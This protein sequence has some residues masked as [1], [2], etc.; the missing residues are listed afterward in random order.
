M[1][2]ENFN[3]SWHKECLKGGVL[4]IPDNL[5][6]LSGWE[7]HGCEDIRIMLMK[8][9]LTKILVKKIILLRIAHIMFL[10]LFLMDASIYSKISNE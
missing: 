6:E 10:L 9:S 5:T 3:D 2:K 4:T 7:F 1:T 8:S